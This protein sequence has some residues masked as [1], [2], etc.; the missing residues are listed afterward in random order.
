MVLS[1]Q[2]LI[3]RGEAQ[4]ELSYIPE[5][6]LG[7]EH[8]EPVYYPGES[9]GSLTSIEL[10]EWNGEKMIQDWLS[11]GNHLDEAIHPS[12]RENEKVNLVR[13][14]ILTKAE[15]LEEEAPNLLL[16]FSSETPFLTYGFNGFEGGEDSITLSRFID[17]RGHNRAYVIFFGEVPE[18]TVGGKDGATGEPIEGLEASVTTESMDLFD[19]AGMFIDEFWDELELH[20]DIT[21]KKHMLDRFLA[22]DMMQLDEEQKIFAIGEDLIG[23]IY[24][25][26]RIFYL[27]LDEKIPAGETLTIERNVPASHNYCCGG[28][29]MNYNGYHILAASDFTVDYEETLFSVEDTELLDVFIY[30]N[31]DL[32]ENDGEKEE[33]EKIYDVDREDHLTFIFGKKQ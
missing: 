28:R 14:N 2:E 32:E 23:Q 21:M 3:P 33:K 26:K 13:M 22:E 4:E 24:H 12:L 20:G 11:D 15:D 8:I 27:A 31:E 25:A 29:S 5:I 7:E 1:F 16:S 10:K 19:A 18:L 6:V 30:D 17:E 9:L